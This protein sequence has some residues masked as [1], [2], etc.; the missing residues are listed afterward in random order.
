MNF[1]ILLLSLGDSTMKGYTNLKRKFFSQGQWKD[2]GE[3]Y[4]DIEPQLSESWLRIHHQLIVSVSS[5]STITG[6]IPFMTRDAL[7]G[8]TEKR[9]YKLLEQ[10]R[11]SRSKGD[12]KEEISEKIVSSETDEMQ[13]TIL[14]V[15]PVTI[16]DNGLLRKM[17]VKKMEEKDD[18]SQLSDMERGIQL[19]SRIRRFYSEYYK[20]EVRTLG[21]AIPKSHLCIGASVDGESEDGIIEI[22]APRRI[23]V[24]L[25]KYIEKKTKG[26]SHIW[27]SHWIQMQSYTHILSKK[28]CDYLSYCHEERFIFM[29]RFPRD[30]REGKRIMSMVD[31]FID[32][33]K[34][35]VYSNP[36]CKKLIMEALE[37]FSDKG[38]LLISS[39]KNPVR[40]CREIK[41]LSLSLKE[42]FGSPTAII[43]S[44]SA[45]DRATAKII[46]ESLGIEIRAMKV[47]EVLQLNSNVWYVVGPS[48]V[49]RILETSNVRPLQTFFIETDSED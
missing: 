14:P 12:I 11:V 44:S 29:E 7:L 34:K 41:D 46:G 22:K 33:V 15:L 35:N 10:L 5:F 13:K 45:Q 40:T 26:H 16:Y 19:E 18:I 48:I 39:I 36:R 3:Y 31:G 4:L 1:A 27:N 37:E 49:E 42:Q 38:A 24:P 9:I 17:E 43:S 8:D 20:R 32:D 47:E 30:R 23:P 2:M 28:W 6:D 21:V 25:L